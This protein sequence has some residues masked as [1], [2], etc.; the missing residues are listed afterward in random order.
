MVVG[1]VVVMAG[2][3][4]LQFTTEDVSH[5]TDRVHVDQTGR[6]ALE[7]IMLALHSTCV[8]TPA[9]PVLEGSTN[10][11]IKFVSDSGTGSSLTTV[12]KHEIIYTPKSGSTEGT[13]VEKIFA[14]T[15]GS[16]P[17][18]T[19]SSTAASTT[20]LLRGIRQTKYGE[21]TAN[22]IFSYYRYY[23][24]GDKVPEG[25]SALPYGEINPS[26]LAAPVTSEAEYVTKVTVKFT[27]APEGN[28]GFAF[29]QDRPV[30]LEDSVIFRL[31]PSSEES[32]NLNR[33]CSE[34]A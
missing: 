31:T 1:L 29:N 10:S 18:Y 7:R 3:A 16:A 14:S 20:T 28:E 26:E 15:G 2:F 12:H 21:E 11:V 5:I 33:P 13:L 32:T 25:M 9:V 6:T 27:L 17:K 24:E 30:L 22:P 4:L 19:W 23:R 8:T 34:T